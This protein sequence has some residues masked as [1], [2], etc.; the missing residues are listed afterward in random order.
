[1]EKIIKGDNLTQSKDLVAE[2]IE[3]LKELFP[4]IITDGKVDFKILKE[5]LSEEIESSDENYQLN[6]AGKSH[7]RREAHKPSTGTLRPSKDESVDCD[8]TKNLYI[9]G[10][11]LEVLKIMQK[12][13]AG[14]VKMI[15]IDPP[16]NTGKDF[17]YKDN[18]KDNLKNYQQITG[19]L[20]DDGNK[21]TTNS[22]SEGRYHSNWLNMMYPRLRLARNLLKDDGA[23]FISID[24]NEVENLK[25]IGHEIFGE[26]NFIGQWNWFKSATPPNLST[27]IRKN[28]EF[29]LCYEKKKNVYKYKGVQKVSKSDDPMTKSQNSLKTL[30]FKPG[31]LIIKLNDQTISKGIYGTDTYPNKLLNDLLIK[32]NTNKNTVSFENKFIWVQP[33]LEEEISKNTEMK[34]NSK[35]LVISYKKADYDE[36]VPPSLIDEKVG[37]T[38]TENAGKYLKELM[39]EKVFSYPKP[40]DLIEY[41]INFFGI[42]DEIIMDFFSGSGT[43]AEAVMKNGKNQFIL[44][45]LDQEINPDTITDPSEKQIARNAIELLKST[46]KSFN[47]CEIGKE[48]IRRA[49]K[50]IAEANPEKAKNLD[51]GFKVF[52]LDS[53]N[54]KGWDGN[55]E[56]LEESLFDSISNIKNDRTEEDVLYEILLKYGL[57]LTL[58]I[59]EKKIEGATVFN[60]GLGALFICLADT[61]TSKVAEGIGKWKEELNPEVCRVV[62]KDT[63]F[64][65]VEKTNSV[66]TLKR[67]GITEIK[68]I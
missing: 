13:Y 50:K 26:G 52:K 49:A 41:F 62:F 18:Y 21:L 60:V 11:N 54:I 17:V 33:N 45:Q 31:E 38:T 8:T 30:T 28:I 10:D 59:E 56:N 58:P 3:R 9:E 15:Y 2:N 5:I 65:D 24:D 64:T 57:D 32:N 12:S 67:F 47:L 27:K 7:A 40:L 29:V 68:S 16:Y 20:D 35:S 44:V 4:E 19:Q 1:M 66:Q 22:E 51:L 46:G 23:I 55:P 61:I 39:G 37:V 36:E 25:K 42:K 48:R 63:G 34:I 14:K 6:W 53:S 43:T